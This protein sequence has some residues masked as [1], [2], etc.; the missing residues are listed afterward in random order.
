M[1]P[2]QALPQK[3]WFLPTSLH[4]SFLKLVRA[5]SKREHEVQ[6]T[7]SRLFLDENHQRLISRKTGRPWFQHNGR[8]LTLKPINQNVCLPPCIRFFSL[9]NLYYKIIL[10]NIFNS[11]NG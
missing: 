1:K 2:G 11:I 10:L 7:P 6:E 9:A 4:E 3:P 5:V 8:E